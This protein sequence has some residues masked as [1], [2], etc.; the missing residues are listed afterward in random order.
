MYRIPYHKIRNHKK[1]FQSYKNF[2]KTANL[3]PIQF[4]PDTICAD[5]NCADTICADTICT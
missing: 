3:F 1:K 4:V 2:D 5:T